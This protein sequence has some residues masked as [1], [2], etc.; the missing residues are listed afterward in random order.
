MSGPILPHPCLVL[1]TDRRR[2]RLPLLDAVA[3]AVAAG[4][5]AVQLR[6][7]DLPRDELL[8][9]AHS[10]RRVTTGRSLLLVNGDLALALAAD[11]D[12]VHLPEAGP[13]VAEVRARGGERLLIGRSVHSVA[14]AE[15]AAEEGAEYVQVGAVFATASH[16]GREPSGLDLVRD[17]RS[18]VA[19]LSVRRTPLLAVGGITPENAAE[20][21]AAGA[22]GLAVIGAILG[23]ERPGAVVRRFREVLARGGAGG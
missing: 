17:V 3:E 22:D 8:A 5:D 10:L 21:L 23:S 9:L 15:R 18:A 4:V 14:A 6:E 20:V 12:G 16:P 2:S 1:I 11:A 7:L 13:A 19:P